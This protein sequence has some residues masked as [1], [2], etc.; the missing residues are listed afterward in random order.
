MQKYTRVMFAVVAAA[1]VT[2]TVMGADPEYYVKRATWQETLQASR[3]ALVE[4][5]SKPGADTTATAAPQYGP[6]YSIGN[7]TA[8]NSFTAAYRG[9]PSM[10]ASW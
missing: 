6:W 10:N 8:R 2:G 4:H 3:E 5:L 9:T 1:L 7:Y